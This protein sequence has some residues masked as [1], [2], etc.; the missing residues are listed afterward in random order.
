MYRIITQAGFPVLVE[1]E[2]GSFSEK[3]AVT[4][5]ESW[6]L[7]R[8]KPE[9]VCGDDAYRLQYQRIADSA[10]SKTRGH[11]GSSSLALKK[12]RY[13]KAYRRFIRH[14]TEIAN[15]LKQRKTAIEPIFDLIAKLI[16]T[17]GKQKQD[18]AV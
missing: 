7:Q 8:L 15:L 10:V 17:T 12:G 13:A 2:T 5:K 1:V 18:V 16:G 11:S 14:D 6:I 4:R 9:T 3:D